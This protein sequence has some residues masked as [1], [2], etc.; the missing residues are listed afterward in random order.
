MADLLRKHQTVGGTAVTF[1]LER[2]T[3]YTPTTPSPASHSD[4]K[5]KTKKGITRIAVLHSKA[6][7]AGD[8]VYFTVDGTTPTVKGDGTYVGIVGVP[9]YVNVPAADTRAVKVIGSAA[10]QEVSVWVA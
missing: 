1:S 10:A 9:V 4:A 2:A 5:K 3:V 8:L 7:T 6:A